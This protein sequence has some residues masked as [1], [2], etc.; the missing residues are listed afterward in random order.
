MSG[1]RLSWDGKSSAVKKLHLPLQVVETIN[2]PRADRGTLF[3]SAGEPSAEWQNKLIWGDNEHVLASLLEQHAGTVDLI[4]IDPPFDSRQDYTVEVSVG[5][6]AAVDAT[7]SKIQSV[8]EEKAYRDTWGAGRSSYLQ[9]LLTRLILCRELLSETGSIVVHMDW[10]QGHY[11]K[12]LL[13][14]V[15]G[16]SNFRNEIVWWYYN[17]YQGNINRFASNHDVLLW[18]S[19]SER[20]TFNKIREPRESTIKQIKRVWDPATKKL[21]NAKDPVTGKVLYQ[22]SDERTVDDVWRLSMLQPADKTENVRYETQKPL[23]LVERVITA[24]SNEG[25]LILDC[26]VGSGTTAVAAERLSRRWIGVDIGRFAIHTTRKRLLGVAGCKP[27]VV[28]NLGR[29]ERQV[30]QEKQTGQSY[31]AYLDFV[32]ELYGAKPVGNFVNVHGEVD[33]R[34]VHIGAIDAPVSAEEIFDSLDEAKAAGYEALDVLGWEFELGLHD[35]IEHEAD[36]RGVALRLRRIPIEVMDSRAVAEGN[37]VFHELAYVDVEAEPK[38]LQLVVTLK[39]FV[40]P[41][42]DLVPEAVRDAISTWSDYIDYWAIDFTYGSDASVPGDTFRNQW[43]S[44]RTRADRSLELS[45]E[46]A[47]DEPGDYTLLVKVVDIFGNDT[48]TSVP[49]HIS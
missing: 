46:H 43:Q 34:A 40:L 11:A 2:S 44:F 3:E 24:L 37:V 9:M 26:F 23:A 18:Y 7:Y 1:V 8:I 35:A 48:T 12:L 29:Y 28:A 20:Y 10:H 16:E 41:N 6:G 27:F 33:R 42:P 4:Y 32:C 14:E 19:K 47:Y 31:A 5:P 45:A 30:W 49:V 38:G 15:F 17:K 25:D 39:N 13:D 21:V 22:D 36:G